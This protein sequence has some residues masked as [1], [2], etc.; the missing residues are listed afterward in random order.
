MIYFSIVIPVY[1][2]SKN[3]EKLLEEI[4]SNLNLNINYNF[5]IILVNDCSTDNTIEIVNLLKKTYPLSL[6]NNKT[7]IGQSFSLISGIENSTYDTV[8]TLDG[9][10]Q[11][12]PKDIS[13]LLE[14]YFSDQSLSLV[15]GIRSKR[16]DSIIKIFSSKIANKIR[17]VILN[18]SCTDTGCSLKVFDKKIFLKFP[19]FDGMHRFLPALYKGFGNKTFFTNV[20]HRYRN[21][22]SSNYGTLDRLFR[23]IRDMIKVLMIIKNYK[24]KNNLFFINICK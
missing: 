20:D 2:E 3:I 6:L 15:G 8:V 5:E 4:F 13:K 10:L 11:N 23:G 9:D 19:F 21:F 16:K 17:S 22:G 12:N 1:N 24:K 14:I 7:N 18:D